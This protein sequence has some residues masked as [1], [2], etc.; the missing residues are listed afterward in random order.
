MNEHNTIHRD[1]NYIHAEWLL[2]PH[3]GQ[4]FV[5]IKDG[6]G[7]HAVI[8][9]IAYSLFVSHLRNKNLVSIIEQAHI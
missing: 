9:G 7:W 2:A 5:A 6:G 8:G 1:T 3:A 4:R